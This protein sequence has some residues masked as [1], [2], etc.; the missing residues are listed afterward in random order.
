MAFLGQKYPSLQT[1]GNY[2]EIIAT[3]IRLN[4]DIS[5]TRVLVNGNINAYNDAISMFPGLLIAKLFRYKP[6]TLIDEENIAENKKLK[7]ESV[8]FSQF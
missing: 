4:N 5:A 7:K 6:E 1:T 2:G 8:D 3:A